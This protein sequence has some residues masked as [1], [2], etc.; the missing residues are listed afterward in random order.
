MAIRITEDGVVN[1]ENSPDVNRKLFPN[2]NI[3]GKEIDELEEEIN[4]K[5]PA[6]LGTASG[7][8]ASFDDGANDMPLKSCVVSFGPIQDLHG[9]DSPWAAGSGKN[10]ID[11]TALIRGSLNSDGTYVSNDNRTVS[12]FITL[13]AGT[14]TVS[15]V[16]TDHTNYWKMFSYNLDE[17]GA[18][19][20]F[21]N[22]TSTLKNTFTL[23]EDKKIRIAFDYIV[24]ADDKIQLEVGSEPTSYAPYSN[25][26][27]I[28]GRTG[29]K[30]W[31]T[32]KNLLDKSKLT[33]GSGSTARYSTYG[34]DGIASTSPTNGD[35]HLYPGAY[36]VSLSGL[37]STIL[38]GIGVNNSAGVRKGIT[39]N[40]KILTFNITEEDDYKITF[41]V[42]AANFVSWD[43]YDIQLEVGS[44]AT[45]YEPYQGETVT[46]NWETEAGT[47]YGGSLDVVSGKLTVDRG[48][49][50]SYNS[51][52]LPSTWISD[53]DVYAEGTSPTT[54]AQ[55]V[56]KLAEPVEY[57]LTPQEIRTLLGENNIW[58]DAGDVSVDYPA[59]TKTYIDDL[60][61]KTVEV[62]GQTPTITA[63]ENTRYICG[64]VTSL[65]FTPC[66]TGI[67]DVRFT[68]ASISTVL[69]L[70]Q[71]LKLPAWFDPTLLEAGTTYEINV[72]DGIYGVVMSWA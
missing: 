24:T 4:G 58:S 39:Y 68:T 25:I 14:Y 48:Y 51:E 67:C 37:Q 45:D 61:I 1:Y 19:L 13:N 7:S 59:D 28:S 62:T 47:V 22:G 57:Q 60:S 65:T 15:R 72:L 49:I 32:G 17:S 18:T 27:P 12:D 29:L 46:V 40:N 55:V 42:S 31:R 16:S 70:P 44:T 23:S 35:L 50:A 26:C 69:T 56:Y 63:E 9:Y 11:W 53:R 8:T 33:V 38:E 34:S 30:L 2:L 36:T 64:E 20:V 66:E 43:N 54:G 71:T 10:L 3:Y 5:A 52:T 41:V 21:N 6:V